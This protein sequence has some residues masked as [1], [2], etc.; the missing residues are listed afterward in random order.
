V[1]QDYYCDIYT[2]RLCMR[3]VAGEGNDT[4]KQNMR[5]EILE[6]MK[7]DGIPETISWKWAVEAR[8]RAIKEGI[9]EPLK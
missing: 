5:H 9:L 8:N 6:L 7:Q 1:N 2:E 3:L 4:A